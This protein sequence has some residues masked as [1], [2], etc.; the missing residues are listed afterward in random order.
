MVDPFGGTCVTGEVA[1]RLERRWMCGEIEGEYLQGARGRFVDGDSEVARSKLSADQVRHPGMLWDEDGQ[2]P[3]LLANG[4]RTRPIKHYGESEDQSAARC[5][6]PGA[7][8]VK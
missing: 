5:F 2:S 6:G 4:G 7:S 3:P 1:E 8:Q